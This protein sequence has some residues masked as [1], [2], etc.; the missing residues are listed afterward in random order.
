MLLS[1]QRPITDTTHY[2]GNCTVLCA[3][4]LG[5]DEAS[6]IDERKGWQWI[7]SAKAYLDYR[8]GSTWRPARHR[9]HPEHEYF[10]RG[11]N[12]L[13]QVNS[14]VMEKVCPC[15]YCRTGAQFYDAKKP[16]TSVKKLA[17]KAGTA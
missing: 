7:A 5:M 1:A 17:K 13:N 12:L 6:V 15:V 8:S 3:I 10:V 4:S 9:F 2:L 11:I 16:A 14:Q